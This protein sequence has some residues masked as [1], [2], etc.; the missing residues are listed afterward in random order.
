[1]SITSYAQNF[2][3]VM[4]WRA[5]GHIERG[6]YIDVGAQDPVIDS[7]S[8]AFHEHGWQ[9]IHV[10]PT[11]HYAELLRQQRLGDMVIQAAVG[12][13]P[14]VLQFFEIP[15]SGISTADPDIAAQHRERGFNVREITVPCIPLTEIFKVCTQREIHW[16]KIDVE[17]FEKEVLSSWGASSVRPWIVVV[18]STLPLTQ[19]DTHED[20][21][22]IL[23]AYGYTPVYFDGLNRYYVSDVHPELKGAFL[24]PPNVF[25]EFALNGT[26]SASFHKLIEARAQEK[27]NAALAQVEHQRLSINSEIERLTLSHASLDKTHAEEEQNR[28]QR[29][30]ALASQTS[31][32]K[33]E[34][35]SLLRSQAQREQEVAKQLQAVQEERYHQEQ[36]R[37]KREQVLSEQASQSQQQ[38]ETLLHG[39]AQREQEVAAQLLLIQQRAAQE[40]AAQA[41]SHSEQQRA[42]RTQQAERERALNERLKSEQETLRELQ[43]DQTQREKNHEEHS[44]QTRQELERLMRCQIKREQ[45]F[46]V[47]LLAF[48]EQAVQDKS[49]L[50]LSHGSV[51]YALRCQHAE[52]EEELQAQLNAAQSKGLRLQQENA[53]NLQNWDADVL[54]QQK[55]IAEE[56]HQHA[57]E[58]AHLNQELERTSNLAT[59]RE[60]DLST[61]ARV[62]KLLADKRFDEQSSLHTERERVLH[63]NHEESE[64]AILLRLNSSEQLCIKLADRQDMVESA[65]RNERECYVEDIRK[66]T[67]IAAKQS[68]LIGKQKSSYW[69]QYFS[70]FNVLRQDTGV[71]EICRSVSSEFTE[72]EKITGNI[73]TMRPAYKIAYQP[74]FKINP[75]GL[76]DLDEFQRLYDRNFV[77]AAYVA[78]LRREPDAVGETYYLERVR[79]GVSKVKILAQIEESPEAK[80]YKT[81]ITG[82]RFAIVLEKICSIPVVGR[83]ILATIFMLNIKSHLQDLR[84]LENHMVRNAEETQSIHENSVAD[85]RAKLANLK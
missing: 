10:E 83:L 30:H 70:P 32:I 51:I 11:P 22:P 2:E 80:K 64:S 56:A 62:N 44:K 73:I 58:L 82:L 31:Q 37:T 76:Y 7:V 8:L 71:G 81:L 42:L 55:R 59:N 75:D 4:L 53:A 72:R 27:I 49:Q 17:G 48:Q 34:L 40:K 45:E 46:T 14:A 65:F 25:D 36:D 54:L 3:D 67:S 63:Q 41:L 43:L 21:E 1:M 28:A 78:I 5:L 69:Q 39:V 20:W 38:L 84:A 9:G 33:Q 13:G 57:S 85:I 50:T 24:A 19:I 35:E 18:E 61:Q 16:L 74:V 12:Q 6:M 77:Y 26:A 68:Y 15:D 60:L 47:Q 29:E 66:L 23:V 79:K 52:Q